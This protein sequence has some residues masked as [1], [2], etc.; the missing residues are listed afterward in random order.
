MK[1]FLSRFL[2]VLSVLIASS[3]P[4]LG[5]QARSQTVANSNADRF[6]GIWKFNPEG[7][8]PSGITSEQITIEFH[9]GQYKFSGDHLGENGT[10]LH[11]WYVTSMSG[12]TVKPTQV[13]GLPMSDEY[14]V[15]RLAPD[16]FRVESKILKEEY[17]V[18]RDGRIMMIQR[19]YLVLSKGMP[20]LQT[21][22]F[23]RQH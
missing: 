9:D 20:N 21:L 14:R 15:T 7:S 5:P 1:R 17:K 8:S 18:S 23:D 2:I 13:N 10:E 19:K 16:F 6:L 3:S 4:G 11:W 12:E 22:R